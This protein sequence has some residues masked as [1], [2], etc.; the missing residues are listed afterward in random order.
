M[1]VGRPGRNLSS[2]Q[3]SNDVGLEILRSCQI[4]Q[5]ADTEPI[6]INARLNTDC[7]G[8]E[9]IWKTPR[10][11]N[12]SNEMDVTFKHEKRAGL[13]V[14]GTKIFSFVQ[15]NFDTSISYLSG[16]V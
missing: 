13:R 4:Q 3:V 15:V 10:L 7:E 8:K 6:R 11:L 2:V 16:H 5:S 1:D 14:D 9:E 12:M